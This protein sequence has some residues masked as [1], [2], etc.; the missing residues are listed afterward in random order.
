MHNSKNSEPPKRRSWLEKLSQVLTGE[1]KDRTQLVD[2]LRDAHKRQILDAT[3]LSMIEGILY[4][5]D[6]RVKDV[7]IPR[8][9]MT[10]VEKNTNFEEILPVVIKTVHSR[11]P[12]IGENKDEV[13]GILLAKDLLAYGFDKD[14][15]AKFNMQDLLRPAYFV[16]ESK[17]LDIL[18]QEFRQNRNHMAI[19][20]DEYGGVM[21]LITIE[22]V[23][24]QIVG[25][26]EDEYDITDDQ[27]I[28]KH[29]DSTYSVQALTPIEEFNTYFKANLN[30][31]DVETIGGLVTR[32]FNHVP[33]RD[34]TITIDNISFKILRSDSRRINLLQVIMP[35]L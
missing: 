19:V 5:P 20:A 16:P 27:L 9:Q 10:I 26:I 4:V 14:M 33:K 7:M 35:N 22:D 11:Y 17:R 23:L 13:V 28:K 21:G 6:L 24:E 32:A 31:E 34:E 2:V 12:V 1:P 15:Q 25:E 18:L 29:N 3:A 8:S 30:S